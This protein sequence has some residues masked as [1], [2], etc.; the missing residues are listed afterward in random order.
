MDE[1]LRYLY[2]ILCLFFCID[3][4]LSLLALLTALYLKTDLECTHHTLL[5]LKTIIVYGFLC[6]GFFFFSRIYNGLWLYTSLYDFVS[7]VICMSYVTAIFFILLLFIDHEG[8]FSATIALI[9]APFN[10]LYMFGARLGY[11]YLRGRIYRQQNKE[12]AFCKVLIFGVSHATETFLKHLHHD[13]PTT[14]Q[15]MGLLDTFD[16]R[17]GCTLCGA[18]IIGTIKDF[19]HIL[20][21]LAQQK[22]L[23]DLV[24]VGKKTCGFGVIALASQYKI[25]VRYLPPEPPHHH[26]KD[27]CLRLQDMVPSL[28]FKGFDF[29]AFACQDKCFVIAGGDHPLL[30]P[31][32]GQLKKLNMSQIVLIGQFSA[33][34]QEQ[35]NQIK[36]DVKF[37][38]SKLQNT[39]NVYH[40]LRDYDPYIMLFFP[41]IVMP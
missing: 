10:I 15:V 1:I 38:C 3:L 16:T 9:A 33:K 28:P 21:I 24:L 22:M 13:H 30:I 12:L 23:P 4:L 29:K 8:Q 32:L 35:C 34:T 14:Y 26:T 5:M 25:P 31:L 37:I 40:L 2:L 7:I 41:P 19:P 36:Q 17:V 6:S 20:T 18:H 27:Q 39:E 11:R